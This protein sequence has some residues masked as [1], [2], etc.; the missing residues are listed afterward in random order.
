MVSSFGNL[1]SAGS[2][3]WS[4]WFLMSLLEHEGN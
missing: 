4:T 2:G 3:E 1:V